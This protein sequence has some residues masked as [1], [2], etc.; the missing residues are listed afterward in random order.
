[1]G[2]LRNSRGFRCR[3]TRWSCARGLRGE[4]ARYCSTAERSKEIAVG[5]TGASP[6]STRDP[7]YY[8]PPRSD[9]GAVASSVP[10][11]ACVVGDAVPIVASHL[12]KKC[13]RNATAPRSARSGWRY[14][15]SHEGS[16]DSPP[17]DPRLFPSTAPR[18]SS[19]KNPSVAQRHVRGATSTKQWTSGG[20][21]ARSGTR[22]NRQSEPR[23]VRISTAS[24]SERVP[25]NQIAPLRY[26][27]VLRAPSSA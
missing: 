12:G 8:R 16:L 25:Y 3:G 21:D 19:A 6:T 2:F 15:G 22:S 20:G 1:M 23:V 11:G 7:R 9:R 18:S 27:P 13:N 5:R 14:R 26:R 17:C 4:P 24:S 10:E